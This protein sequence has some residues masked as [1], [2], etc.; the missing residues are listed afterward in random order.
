MLLQLPTPDT[1]AIAQ[2][3]QFLRSNSA[4]QSRLLRFPDQSQLS[5][6]KMSQRVLH[7]EHFRNPR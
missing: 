1:H 7:R 4:L 3:L 6:G 5:G 2:R